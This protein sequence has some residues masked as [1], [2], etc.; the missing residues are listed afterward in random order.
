MR[1]EFTRKTRWEAGERAGGICQKCKLI[2]NGRQEYDHIL[3]CELG[4]DNSLS[5]CM[6]LCRKCHADKTAT[7]VRQIRKA[8]RARDK[9]A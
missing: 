6:V 7:D 4:G 3:P 2:I 5:N 1:Q 8:D 9:A